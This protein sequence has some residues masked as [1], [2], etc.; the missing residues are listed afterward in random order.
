MFEVYVP[1]KVVSFVAAVFC[2][3]YFAKNSGVF[4]SRLNG[5]G[6]HT[7]YTRS[8]SVDFV[9]SRLPQLLVAKMLFW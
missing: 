3:W 4:V 9:R 2:K 5:E 8:N 1:K 7:V 6:K